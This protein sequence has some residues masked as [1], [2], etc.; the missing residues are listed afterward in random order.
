MTSSVTNGILGPTVPSFSLQQLKIDIKPPVI[1]A[2]LFQGSMDFSTSFWLR[3]YFE[4][5]SEPDLGPLTYNSSSTE[6]RKS[7]HE[8]SDAIVAGLW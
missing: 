4:A 6:V 5:S 8:D 1:L 2:S 3:Y 7:S